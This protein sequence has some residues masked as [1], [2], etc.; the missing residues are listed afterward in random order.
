MKK[1]KTWTATAVKN[2]LGVAFEAAHKGP[3]I[4]H[5]GPGRGGK[6]Q[7]FALMTLD[8]MMAMLKLTPAQKITFAEGLGT[9]I[10][11]ASVKS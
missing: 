9:S 3:V 10:V 8:G 7:H 11:A 4:I 6:T 1:P 5:R 2:N